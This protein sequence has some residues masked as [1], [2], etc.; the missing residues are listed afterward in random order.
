MQF[1]VA[2]LGLLGGIVGRVGVK[3]LQYRGQYAIH[4]RVHIDHIDIFAVNG[5]DEC[6]DLL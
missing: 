3:F 6:L 1:I 2:L 5:L 4:D